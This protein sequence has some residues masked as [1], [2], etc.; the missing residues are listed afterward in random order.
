MAKYGLSGTL[1]VLLNGRL[2][3]GLVSCGI[4]RDQLHL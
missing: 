3:G 1:K 4:V 2:V